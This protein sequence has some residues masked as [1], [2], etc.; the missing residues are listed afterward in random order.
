MPNSHITNF[1]N[2]VV[3]K[4]ST[5]INSHNNSDDAHSSLF[6]AKANAEHSHSYN[7]LS[8]KPTIPSANSTAT[9][10]K[11]DGT[12]S[13]G[14]LS[15]FAKADHVHPTDTSRAAAT[16]SHTKSEITDFPTSMTPNS[17][18]HGDLTNDGVIST[19]AVAKDT[20]DYPIVA[21]NS[22]SKKLKR[23]YIY[24]GFV[25][26]NYARPNIGTAAQAT[27]TAVNQAIDT[28]LGNKVDTSDSRLSDARN[29][30]ITKIPSN[31]DLNNYTTAG[32]YYNDYN[33]D[34]ETIANR[35]SYGVKAFY[36]QVEKWANDNNIKQTISSYHHQPPSPLI[37][38]RT[39]NGANTWSDWRQISTYN[40]PKF[41]DN[42]TTLTSTG[43]GTDTLRLADGYFFQNK[44]NNW[45]IMGEIKVTG[46]AARFEVQ[47]PTN[48][49]ANNLIAIG[50]NTG[51]NY[52]TWWSTSASAEDGHN[53]ANV[54]FNN[55][56]WY[57]FSM[58]KRDN[59]VTFNFN[60][61]KS[62]TQLPSYMNGHTYLTPQLRTWTTSNVSIRN[63][64]I[65][66]HITDSL[67]DVTTNIDFN[68]YKK[69]GKY[70][71]WSAK[72][73]GNTNAPDTQGGLLEVKAIPNGV[74]QTLSQYYAE[75]PKIFYRIFHATAGWRAWKEVVTSD[76]TRLTNARTPTSHASTAT[77]YGAS[78][79]SNYGHAMASSTSPK[80]NG[81]AAV[82]SETAKFA[83]GDHV[84]PH[85]CVNNL[86]STSTTAPLAANQGR[87]LKNSLAWTQVAQPVTG[88]TLYA[89]D[90]LCMCVID[91]PSASIVVNTGKLDE[92]ASAFPSAYRPPQRVATPNTFGSDANSYSVDIFVD[93]D[94]FVKTRSVRAWSSLNVGG[95]LMWGR[96]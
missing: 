73:T 47:V 78:S 91:Y 42:E 60:N 74:K 49:D 2:A 81:T 94:G 61:T 48:T 95:V 57:P 92:N 55:N 72:Q 5:L 66:P 23:G 86:S 16:H 38:V 50:K 79:A 82:G 17:H 39:K 67:Q 76:D 8:N 75:N 51:G 18:T 20:G 88:I 85:N 70:L 3:N 9:N 63:L 34:A 32:F 21:D 93:T 7:E 11:M 1:V 84:H 41:I 80:A 15:T 33:V 77:T 37:Y 35:P 44:N 27:Q 71:I 89:N 59:T 30:K 6:S 64:K 29:P 65:I 68:D 45:A 96:I 40:E 28:A 87:V 90:Y 10:I 24:T 26:D 19:S 83:R 69:E 12:Q 53:D 58:V 54:T 52:S 22:D 31:S 56:T 62:H 14:S 43:S 25:W 36:L 46:P 4:A 13:A